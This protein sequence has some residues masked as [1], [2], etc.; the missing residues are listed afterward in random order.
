[1][2]IPANSSHYLSR[3]RTSKNLLPQKHRPLERST[4]SKLCACSHF[5]LIYGIAIATLSVLA[6]THLILSSRSLHSP[7]LTDLP[8]QIRS[9]SIK[10]LPADT[11]QTNTVA[12]QDPQST[13]ICVSREPLKA[14]LSK[15]I[16]FIMQKIIDPPKNSQLPIIYRDLDGN[17]NLNNNISVWI[18][19]TTTADYFRLSLPGNR[20]LPSTKGICYQENTRLATCSKVRINEQDPMIPFICDIRH[21]SLFCK[22]SQ[23]ATYQ[24]FNEYY[25]LTNLNG[26]LSIQESIIENTP[27][28]YSPKWKPIPRIKQLPLDVLFSQNDALLEHRISMHPVFDVLPDKQLLPSKRPS[29]YNYI[30]SK[31][32]KVKTA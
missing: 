27:S 5:Q 30:V 32:M 21:Q 11:A 4:L 26:L 13:I 31:F 22:D 17:T 9:L 1:M 7:H 8:S 29:H 14:D 18:Q 6:T 20:Y 15:I 2:K 23:K 25:T 3:K 10:I 19:K 28:Y 16:A 12:L 24:L